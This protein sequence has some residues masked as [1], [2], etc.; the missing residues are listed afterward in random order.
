MTGMYFVVL[1]SIHSLL[2]QYFSF[3]MVIIG[4][5]RVEAWLILTDWRRHEVAQGP[6][7]GAL[8]VDVGDRHIGPVV[9]SFM[10]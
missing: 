8:A 9:A 7:A 1:D 10:A 2:T 6:Y 4:L 5:S 3:F